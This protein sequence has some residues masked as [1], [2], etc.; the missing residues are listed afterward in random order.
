MPSKH[1]HRLP[2]LLIQLLEQQQRLFFQPKTAL[3]VAVDDVEGVL[4]PV[5]CDVVAF[6]GLPGV[7]VRRVCFYGEGRD[8]KGVGDVLLVGLLGRGLRC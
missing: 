1:K 8:G 5:V 7:L 6:E 2:A 4:S 3:L